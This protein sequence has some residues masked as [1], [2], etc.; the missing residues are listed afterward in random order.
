MI[1][2]LIKNIDT[3]NKNIIITSSKIDIK[4]DYKKFT[5]NN[6]NEDDNTNK[7]IFNKKISILITLIIIKLQCYQ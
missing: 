4:N 7:N 2:L 1:I 3:T 5:T 6:Y